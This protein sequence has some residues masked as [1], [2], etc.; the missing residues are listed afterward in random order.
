M[1]TLSLLMVALALAGCGDS[2]VQNAHKA[3]A[4]RLM[5]PESAKF[6]EDRELSDGSVC[7]QV[8]G[9][10]SY[11]AY[12]GFGNYLARKGP[13]G[14]EVVLDPQSTN[15]DAA[16]ACGYPLTA[17]PAPAVA[18][19]PVAV[20]AA[21]GSGEIAGVRWSV[22]LAS[23]SPESARLISQKLAG[24][25]YSPYVAREDN[26][27]RVYVGPFGSRSEATHTL[28][29]LRHDH[30]IRGVVVRYRGTGDLPVP[31]VAHG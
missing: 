1:R 23:T 11:G 4:Y 3:V 22:Q 7:G 28:D 27:S 12:S 13:D 10:N 5:D 14:F 21:K 29:S 2:A 8:N 6:R 9:K 16:K 15:A 18:A 31:A 30:K 20:A 17:V 26:V 25:G 24:F 19:A